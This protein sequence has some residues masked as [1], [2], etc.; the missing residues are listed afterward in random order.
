MASDRT[1]G[2]KWR[3]PLRAG[4]IYPLGRYKQKIGER[5]RELVGG[6]CLETKSG[7]GEAGKEYQGMNESPHQVAH[8]A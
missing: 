8:S 6:L 4:P 5:Y 2:K 1:A 7:Q 3:A